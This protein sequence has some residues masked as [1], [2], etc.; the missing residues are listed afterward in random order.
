[1]SADRVPVPDV[2]VHHFAT[3]ID[4]R[5]SLTEIFRSSWGGVPIRQWTAMSLGAGVIRGP[6]VHRRHS[7]AVIALTGVLQIGLR[8]LREKSPA[9]RQTSRLTLPGLQP[10]VVFIPPG[11]MH[12]F[13]AATEPTLVLVYDAGGPSPELFPVG[14]LDFDL[15]IRVARCGWII[16]AS[17]QSL[18]RHKSH[19]STSD[20]VRSYTGWRNRRLV[21]GIPIGS[22]SVR[23][24]RR[25]TRCAAGSWLARPGF[26]PSRRRPARTRPP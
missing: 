25:G 9:F 7:D 22:A 11:V 5:G 4:D 23:A 24:G 26:G 21:G 10:M 2:V 12:T 1:M 17:S 8:D 3:H 6:S 18:V 19:Q 14:Y 20:A 15:C 16:E 13:Y